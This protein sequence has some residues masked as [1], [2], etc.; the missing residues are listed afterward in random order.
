MAVRAYCLPT[1]SRHPERIEIRNKW[2]LK[3]AKS[4]VGYIG[5]EVSRLGVIQARSRRSETSEVSPQTPVDL[6]ERHDNKVHLP[7]TQPRRRYRPALRMCALV[8]RS[9]RPHRALAGV[10]L[11]GPLA[12]RNPNSNRRRRG[13]IEKARVQCSACVFACR[14]RAVGVETACAPGIASWVA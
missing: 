12:D 3:Y 13:R 4:G 5:F 9:H 6:V 2:A 7:G 14:S 1:S 11:F 10:T 8:D